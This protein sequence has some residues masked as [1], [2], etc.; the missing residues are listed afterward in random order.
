M[1]QTERLN[2]RLRTFVVAEAERIGV[3]AAA[4]NIGVSRNTVYRWR[5]RASELG[6]RPCRPHHS[7]RRTDPEREAASVAARLE[8][9]WGPG[10]DRSTHRDP[11]ADRLSDPARFNMQGLRE[12]FPEA[13]PARGVFRAT[14][15]GEAVQIDVKSAGGLARGGGRQ[16]GSQPRQGRTR[17]NLGQ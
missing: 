1:Y 15:P 17:I 4:R 14:D 10:P 8:C 11:S 3:S 16:H 2:P 7:P 5:R 12:L 6:D 9:R 13:R